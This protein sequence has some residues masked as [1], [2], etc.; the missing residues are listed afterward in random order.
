MMSSHWAWADWILKYFCYRPHRLILSMAIILDH[1]NRQATM[2]QT[3]PL[4]IRHKRMQST[5][6]T[7]TFAQG[8]LSLGFCCLL[9]QKRRQT[10]WKKNKLSSSNKWSDLLQ[11]GSFVCFN[12][13]FPHEWNKTLEFEMK[14]FVYALQSQRRSFRIWSIRWVFGHH[15]HWIDR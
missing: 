6:E 15:N 9:D 5:I 4:I 8:W 14:Y 13:G 2:W 3:L 7:E 1:S 11:C 10:M 12:G